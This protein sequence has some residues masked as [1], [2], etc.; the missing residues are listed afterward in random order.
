VD[1]IA[2]ARVNA[3]LRD[4]LSELLAR[5]V[6]DPRVEPVTLIGVEVSRDLSVAKVYYSVFGDE[7][8]QEAAQRGLD[9]VAGFLR[10]EAGRRLRLRTSPQL[11]FLFDAS[12]ERGQR[13]E[14]L[15]REVHDDPHAEPA[16]DPEGPKDV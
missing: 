4:I 13:I 1:P 7:D 2:R 10:G 16:P 11:R 15:L 3:S 8:V 14:Q 12:L 5:R 6:R 9:S